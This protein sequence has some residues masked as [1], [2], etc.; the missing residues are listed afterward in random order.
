MT[1]ATYPL[2]LTFGLSSHARPGAWLLQDGHTG[3]DRS[4][5]E[6]DAR[7]RSGYYFISLST[8]LET[9]AEELS[10]SGL[11]AS[12]MIEQLIRDLEYMQ[13]HYVVTKRSAR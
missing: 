6:L 9:V 5:L 7:A 2:S 13:E 4:S 10:R 1:S 3:G 8:A 12:P 11:P